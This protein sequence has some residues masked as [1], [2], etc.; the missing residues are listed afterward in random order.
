VSGR[1]THEFFVFALFPGAFG[2]VF[3]I[4]GVLSRE[5]FVEMSVSGESGF[6]EGA[7]LPLALAAR[8]PAAG[9][10]IAGGT[11]ELGFIRVVRSW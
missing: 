9:K 3:M 11:S 4:R 10:V 1:N 7:L 5:E 2:A 6:I 8:L